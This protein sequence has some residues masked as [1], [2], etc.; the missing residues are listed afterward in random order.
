MFT[1]RPT[2][3]LPVILFEGKEIEWVS[4]FKYLGLTITR[5][6]N[7]ST[8]INKIS[9]NLSRITGSFMNL[10]SFIPRQILLKLFYALA[11]PHIQNHIVIWGASPASHLKTLSVRMNNMLRVIQRVTRVNGRPTISN[12]DLYKQLGILNLTSIFRYNLF[13]F[14][15]L[16]IDGKLPEFWN[17]LMSEYVAPH[18]YNTRQHMFRHPA[19]VCEI[20]RRALSHQLILLYES[21]PRHFLDLNFNA[22]LKMFKQSLLD[23]Q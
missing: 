22:S 8:H 4:E 19:L 16:L 21:I 11:Y 5:N 17:I 9:L 6:L 14:L 23:I 12:N 3:N 7:F 20:E 1:S 2:P 15:R 13:K 10:R 18:S